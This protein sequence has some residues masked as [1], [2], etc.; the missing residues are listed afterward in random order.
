MINVSK[1]NNNYIERFLARIEQAVED[2]TYVHPE[3]VKKADAF[4][5][6]RVGIINRQAERLLNKVKK[7]NDD[8]D[9]ELE[10]LGLSTE[11]T[12]EELTS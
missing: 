6:H 9:K 4:Y 8:V 3:D 5:D 2:D 10:A 1:F 11:V 12:E 7:E